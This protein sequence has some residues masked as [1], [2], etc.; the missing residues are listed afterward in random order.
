MLR[1]PAFPQSIPNATNT[2]AIDLCQARYADTGY[3]I[4]NTHYFI[5]KPL[6]TPINQTTP[7]CQQSNSPTYENFSM[8]AHLPTQKTYLSACEL[9]LSLSGQTTFHAG[10]FVGFAP[11]RRFSSFT[12]NAPRP[13]ERNAKGSAVLPSTADPV[14][15]P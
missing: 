13:E 11:L 12:D 7:T 1:Y 6:A 10:D 5:L 14:P 8:S 2:P 9:L 4:L 3:S 15:I